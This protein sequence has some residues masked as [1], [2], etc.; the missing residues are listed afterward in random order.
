MK[1]ASDT[2]DIYLLVAY[3]S[4]SRIFILIVICKGFL[5]HI[6][7]H[8]APEEGF[9]LQTEIFSVFI[10]H[11]IKTKN[12]NRSLNKLKNLGRDRLLQ[13]K[14]LRQKSGLCCFSFARYSQKCVTQIY[15]ALYGDTTFVPFL[16]AQTWRP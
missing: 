7:F 8:S 4:L 15:R 6:F 2:S 10:S 9:V 3:Q 13:Y 14:Q 5:S 16:G 11:V 1:H 12:P